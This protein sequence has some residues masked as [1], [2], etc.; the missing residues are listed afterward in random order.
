MALMP[1]LLPIHL[2]TAFVVPANAERIPCQ[3]SYQ[4]LDDSMP[5][6]IDQARRARPLDPAAAVQSNV[7]LNVPRKCLVPGWSSQQQHLQPPG[8]ECVATK[9][10]EDVR[11][12]LMKP[13]GQ[14]KIRLSVFLVVAFHEPLLPA[15]GIEMCLEAQFH[16]DKLQTLSW[17]PKVQQ[18]AETE[19]QCIVKKNVIFQLLEEAVPR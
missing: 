9:R 10:Q 15:L 5:G 14:P 17:H 16:D 18:Y 13:T 3:Q 19:G 4:L 2:G 1:G 8:F 12:H 11:V 6:L 7:I